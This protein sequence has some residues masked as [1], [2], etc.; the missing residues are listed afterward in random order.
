[1]NQEEYDKLIQLM[2][3]GGD[4]FRIA[5]QILGEDK[6]LEY[7]E[8]QKELILNGS[9]KPFID[10]DFTIT[11]GKQHVT[12]RYA[13]TGDCYKFGDKIL[14]RVY[15]N[16]VRASNP[17]WFI[18]DVNYSFRTAQHSKVKINSFLTLIEECILLIIN[19]Y[20]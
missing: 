5:V 8:Q 1:M 13:G 20:F 19:E 3:S 6:T 16:H 2:Q 11:P 12:R 18:N 17:H 4:N 7:L 14:T 15:D 10:K 9:I